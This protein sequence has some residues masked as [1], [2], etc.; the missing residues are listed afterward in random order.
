MAGED[1]VSAS[2]KA[3]SRDRIIVQIACV[4]L[5][6]VALVSF[7][8]IFWTSIVG[9]ICNILLAA[10]GIVGTWLGHALLLLIFLILV[11]IFGI[12]QAISLF[13]WIAAFGYCDDKFC[14]GWSCSCGWVVYGFFMAVIALVV[15]I[16]MLIFGW[17]V[18][19]QVGGTEAVST[20]T[21]T[22]TTTTVSHNNTA[23]Q[24]SQA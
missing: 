12:F 8:A 20:S 17:R 3:Q 2:F 6:L 14:N 24:Q 1:D 9:G 16:V 11:L 4:V 13:F 18:F 23:G 15:Y 21:T 5:I 19:Q 22:T 10:L 7:G